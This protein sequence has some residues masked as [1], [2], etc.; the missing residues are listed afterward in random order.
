MDPDSVAGDISAASREAVADALARLCDEWGE[1]P[2]ERKRWDLTAVEWDDDRERFA[3]GTVGGAGA[4]V[5]RDDGRALVVRHEGETA[6]SEPGGKQEPDESLATAAVRETREETGITVALDG[7]VTAHR[8]A[9]H[10]P[11]RPPLYRLIA[12]FS[13]HPVA[14]PTSLDPREGEI[15]EAR[16]IADHPDDLLYPE[17]AEF[18]L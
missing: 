13:A 10:A 2:V 8:I 15:A 6:W 16:W 9:E 4:W 7:V 17:V 5:R 14:D 11:D 3:A 1:F 18:P 12:V